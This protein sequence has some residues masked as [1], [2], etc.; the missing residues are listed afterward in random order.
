MKTPSP[1]AD[2]IQE[3]V[4]FLPTLSAKGLKPVKTWGGGQETSANV[5]VLPW[6]E[7][8][9]IVEAFFEVAAKDCWADRQYLSREIL[10]RLDEPG[11]IEN[12]D[13]AEIKTILTFCV[14]GERF[15][16]GYWG[17]MIEQDYIR[18]VPQRLSVLA[19]EGACQ[20]P[21]PSPG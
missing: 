13:L 7:Y 15:C 18:R 20:S 17:A 1:T 21:G 11:V 2:D 12:A 19:V 6:P 8:E 5:F 9:Q 4:D 10:D 16:M 3:L 14:R